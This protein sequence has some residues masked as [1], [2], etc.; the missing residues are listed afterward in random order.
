VLVPVV[1]VVPV[2]PVLVPLLQPARQL[3]MTR[4]AAMK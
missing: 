3:N 2:E 4:L 1:P